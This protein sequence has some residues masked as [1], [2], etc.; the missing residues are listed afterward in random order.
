MISLEIR[1]AA[2]CHH[3]NM[4]DAEIPK[5]FFGDPLGGRMPSR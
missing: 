3:A 4:L 2:G 1:S 5:D